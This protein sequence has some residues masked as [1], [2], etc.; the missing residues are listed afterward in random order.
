MKLLFAPMGIVAGLLAGLVAQKGFERLWAAFD[1]EEPPE[2]AQRSA[3]YP[4]LVAALAVEGAVFRVTKGVVDHG[5]RGAFA[6]MTGTWPGEK[7]P[8]KSTAS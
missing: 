7:S 2:P 6:R 3:S 5:A 1:E 8:E 4:K